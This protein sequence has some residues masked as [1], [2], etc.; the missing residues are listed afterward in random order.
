MDIPLTSLPCAYSCHYTPAGNIALCVYSVKQHRKSPAGKRAGVDVWAYILISFK[1]TGSRKGVPLNKE[2]CD[3]L[4]APVDVSK[5]RLQ[6]NQNHANRA[7]NNEV[8]YS[9]YSAI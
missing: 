9:A 3:S 4:L 6:I 2:P 5:K 7:A 8:T 1:H